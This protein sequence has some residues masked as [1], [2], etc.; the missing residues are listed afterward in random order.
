MPCRQ[1]CT[2]DPKS[3]QRGHGKGDARLLGDFLQITDRHAQRA[4]E[5]VRF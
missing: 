5:I 4:G 1:V 2:P 3:D